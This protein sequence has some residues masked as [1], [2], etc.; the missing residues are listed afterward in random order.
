MTEISLI[1]ESIDELFAGLDSKT[2]ISKTVLDD[3]DALIKQLRISQTTIQDKA[4]KEDMKM[5]IKTYVAK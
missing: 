5:K 1:V 4:L 3:I 2:V